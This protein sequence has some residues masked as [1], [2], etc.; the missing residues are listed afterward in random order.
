MKITNQITLSLV[1]VFSSLGFAQ[2]TDVSEIVY[3]S[4]TSRFLQK[5]KPDRIGHFSIFNGPNLQFDRNPNEADGSEDTDGIRSWHQVSFQYQMTENLRFVIN[6][7]FSV[8]YN[9]I[10]AQGTNP[11][12]TP[13]SPV[14]GV[15]GTFYQNGRFSWSGGVNTVFWVFDEAKREEGLIANPGGFQTLNFQINPKL[16]V[17]TW[18][19]AR[20]EVYTSHEE[21]GDIPLFTAPYVNYSFNDNN[22]LMAFYQTEGEIPNTTKRLEWDTN[23]HFNLLYSYSISKNLTIQ[24]IVTLFRATDFNV[25]QGNL[26]LWLSGRFL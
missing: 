23:E 13:E 11:V 2:T 8:T 1:F 10:E 7:R 24:P 22:S 16:S 15:A 17:G 20:Y 21:N 26:N 18:L 5:I 14:F 25:S 3:N 4:N 12:I 19:W 6:P 9:Q